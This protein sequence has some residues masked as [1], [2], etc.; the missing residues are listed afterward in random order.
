M[1]NYEQR[2]SAK[3]PWLRSMYVLNFHVFFR[4]MED[5]KDPDSYHATL[6]PKFV[7][8]PLSAFDGQSSLVILVL[9]WVPC[10]SNVPLER[11]GVML[12]LR[13]PIGCSFQL[14]STSPTSRIYLEL[15]AQG[16]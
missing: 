9:V 6:L 8:V 5:H 11:V 1:C 10:R 14:R 12:C 15:A 16:S 13:L 4:S 7:V 3:R 2:D